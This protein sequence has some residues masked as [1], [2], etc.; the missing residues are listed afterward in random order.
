MTSPQA[1]TEYAQ[2][3]ASRWWLRR[4]LSSGHDAER[5]LWLSRQLQGLVQDATFSISSDTQ[6]KVT[7][8]LERLK[9]VAPYTVSG[10]R[11]GRGG[12]GGGGGE[13]EGAGRRGGQDSARKCRHVPSLLFFEVFVCLRY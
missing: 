8:M 6:V 7:H 5:Y 3:Y 10:Q 2:D 9:D 1:I 13:R 4:V 12:E 11:G